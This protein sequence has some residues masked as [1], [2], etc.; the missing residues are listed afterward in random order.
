[1]ASWSDAGGLAS[2]T[3]LVQLPAPAVSG[4]RAV[5]SEGV[6]YHLVSRIM[7]LKADAPKYNIYC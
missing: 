6:G 1:L 7:D 4:L 3:T 2:K 5:G